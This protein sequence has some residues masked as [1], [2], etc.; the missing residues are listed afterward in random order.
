MNIIGTILILGALYALL[1]IAVL[2]IVSKVT[3]SAFVISLTNDKGHISA[4]AVL[5]PVT[6][7][8]AALLLLA[9]I[10]V[11]FMDQVLDW[12]E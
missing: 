6:I 1:G 3:N 5:W 2:W 8:C 10:L 7:I 12:L 4:L 9:V 11:W